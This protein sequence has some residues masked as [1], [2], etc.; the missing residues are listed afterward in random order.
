MFHIVTQALW[1]WSQVSPLFWFH[2]EDQGPPG[3]GIS[4]SPSVT[5]KYLCCHCIWLVIYGYHLSSSRIFFF[6]YKPLKLY[7]F[8]KIIE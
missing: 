5:Y 2:T 7:V 3:I 8:G 1:G 6:Q 4:N